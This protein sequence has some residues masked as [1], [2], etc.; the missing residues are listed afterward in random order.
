M[1]QKQNTIFFMIILRALEFRNNLN[2]S[3]IIVSL[4]ST[5]FR[6]L[7]KKIHIGNRVAVAGNRTI[8]QRDQ[9]ISSSYI[10]IQ[11]SIFIFIFPLSFCRVRVGGQSGHEPPQKSSWATILTI[12]LRA[13]TN[14]LRAATK[15]EESHHKGGWI[16][17]MLQLFY[18][19]T[20]LYGW[21]DKN[22][23]SI[24]VCH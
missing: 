14:I 23:N 13:A 22:W 6:S 11:Y 3:N 24:N 5:I 20:L 1:K 4:P 12:T 17:R 21:N 15:E 8:H 2:L 16:S 10:H 9:G 19:I 7:W 18:I